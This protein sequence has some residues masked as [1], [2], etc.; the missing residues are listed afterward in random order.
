MRKVYIQSDNIVSSLG[1][2]S[3]ENFNALV[4]NSTGVKMN[5]TGNIYKELPLSLI[6]KEAFIKK[7]ESSIRNF[8][9]YTFFEQIMIWS[10]VDALSKVNIDA[11]SDRTIFVISTTKGNIDNLK[12]KEGRQSDNYKLWYSAK[13]V[14]DYFSN[15]NEAVVVSN[16]CVSGVMAVNTAA[17]LLQTGAFDH[18]VVI[19]ADVVSDFVIAGFMSFMALSPKPCKPF[20]DNRDG[21]SLGEA[22]G[23]LVLSTEEHSDIA[24]IGGANANDANHISGP[25]RTAEGLYLAIESSMKEARITAS[26]IDYVS[27]HGTATMYNDE[28]E[29]IALNR[30]G[31]QQTPVNSFKGYWGHTLGASGIIEIVASI[32]SME[33]KLLIKSLGFDEKNNGEQINVISKNITKEVNIVLKTA[34]GFGGANSS[35]ILKK[36]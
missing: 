36:Y 29:S 16:A 20:D 27:A 2:T 7:S 11:S 12:T 13:R 15:N 22:A 28:M 8:Q 9:S 17:Q 19:G 21:L 32:K 24:I 26:D 18:A 34:A 33:N 35:I 30:H 1:I 6:D 31:L 23:C 14:C 5:Y 25:S 10:A 3:E 4:D